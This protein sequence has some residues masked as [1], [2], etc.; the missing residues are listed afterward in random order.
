MR[1]Y[2]QQLT[3]TLTAD[4]A[5]SLSVAL[6]EYLRYTEQALKTNPTHRGE[7][8]HPDSCMGRASRLLHNLERVAC[9]DKSSDVA[10]QVTYTMVRKAV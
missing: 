1:D 3:I 10:K 4:E 8:P 9:G 5:T 2:E 6:S 7:A